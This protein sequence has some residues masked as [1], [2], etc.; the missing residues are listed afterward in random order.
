MDNIKSLVVLLAGVAFLAVAIVAQATDPAVKLGV[1]QPS[2]A[3]S[4]AAGSNGFFADPNGSIYACAGA[5][6]VLIGSAGAK[7]F[8]TSTATAT[9]T[10]T[11]TSTP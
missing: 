10:P 11:A 4:C 9:P 6:R 7:A 1:P 8:A 2:A 5:N 3:P